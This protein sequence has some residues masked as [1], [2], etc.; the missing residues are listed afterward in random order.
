MTPKENLLRA[1]RHDN[2]Q[3]VPNGIESMRIT[4]FL[5]PPV[6]ERPMA[7]GTDDWGVK[8]L[9][10]LSSEDGTYPAQ[11]GHVIT[12]ICEWREKIRIP[13][14]DAMDW[15]NIA[16]GW[17]RKK[18]DLSAIDRE[19]RIVTG[20]VR[21]GIFERIYTLLGMENA[22]VSFLS[23]P[24]E[25][26]ALAEAIADYKIRLIRKL[27]AVE[28]LDIIWY[29]DD[30]GTQE[31]LFIPP[32]VWRKI[33]KP[34]TKRIYDCAKEL[35]I[36]INQHSCGKIESIFA[37]FVEIGPD[38]WNPCQACNN[39]A[40]LKKKFGDRIC[41]LGAIDSQMMGTPG[42]TPEEVRAEVRKRIDQLAAG[43]GYIAAPSQMTVYDKEIMAAVM[44]E[45][46]TYGREVYR[47]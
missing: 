43:G 23:E 35:G 47:K 46:N 19:S 3:W 10:C 44:H 37:D 30:W 22:M 34:H 9:M 20:L 40:E 13:D 1:I 27:N 32:E 45:I 31:N 25:M 42:V 11:D 21:I 39:L 28:T 41:F 16:E 14:V 2:P 15:D 7:E 24:E 38:I 8:Y 12:D 36:M 17:D 18:I 33:I 5:D 6:V 26:L 29:S 4:L